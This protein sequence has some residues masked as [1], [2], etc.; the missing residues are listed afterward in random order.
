VVCA[1]GGLPGDLLKLWRAET[2]GSY[3][4]EY[5]YSCM[6]YEI[7]GGLGVKLARPES[8][9]YVMVGDGSYLM[10]SGELATSIQEG[11]KL[12]VVLLDNHGFG[13][14]HGLAESCG[15]HNT[16]NQFRFR[17][18]STGLLSGQSLPIDLAANAASLGAEVLCPEGA[19]GLKQAL[20]QARKNSKTTVIVVEVDPEQRVPSYE[21][22]WDVPV[23]AVSASE[24]VQRARRE[25]EEQRTRERWFI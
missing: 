5:G 7:A 23:A 6:G 19:S 18:P 4:L 21:S 8:E 3:H 2:P 24:S 25:Y 22:W 14:I 16:F 13:C 12:T 9:V 17:E 15:A 11:L 1:A 10:L 20:Q